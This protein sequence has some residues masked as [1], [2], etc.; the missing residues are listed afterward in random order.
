MG[1]HLGKQSIKFDK[2]VS[3][4]ATS[5]LVGKIEGEGPLGDYFDII[6]DDVSYG[7][8]TWEKAESRMVETNIKNVIRKS[9]LPIDKIDYI[10]SG[11]LLNQCCGSSYGVEKL[12]IPF[13]G[14]FGACSTFGEAMGIGSI[15]ID[16][17]GADNVIVGASSH[18]CTAER[19]FRFPLELG[20]QRPPTSTR[21]V[22]GD[23]AVLLS[24]KDKPPFVT[25]ITTGKII[26]M[27]IKDTNNMG[28][29]MAPACADLI[30][31][32][33]NDFGTTANDY[34]F[35]VTGDLGYVGSELLVEQLKKNGI[36]ISNNHIDCG[37]EIYDKNKQDTHSGGSGCACSAVTF[38]SMLFNKLKANDINR[39]LFVP[40][41]ALMSSTSIQQGQ[42]IAGIAHGVLIENGG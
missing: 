24:A 12:N 30:L 40:T 19:Q 6:V 20:T 35:I 21:T 42:S 39:L 38:C 10:I 7:E 9:G 26:D 41:G 4:M 37:I 32:H 11:D 34:D 14:V 3:I 15:L 1:K 27:G 5:S 31:A 33:F 8:N 29:A 18:F 28:A 25:G 17:G 13:L 22:T 2:R 16:G 36:D 23:G